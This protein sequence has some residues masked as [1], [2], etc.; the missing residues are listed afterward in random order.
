MIRVL[1]YET[2][3]FVFY[4]M[5]LSFFEWWFHKFMFHSPK[6]SKR[7][8]REHTLVHHQEFKHEP[9]SYEWHAPREKKNISMDWWSLPLFIVTLAP[10][11]VL[12]QFITHIPT[13][14]GG[15]A[16]VVVYY[17]IYE[18][19]HYLMHVPGRFWIEKTRFFQFVKEHHRI[20]H[21]YMLKNLNVFFPLA[22]V[23]MGTYR[24]ATSPS[25]V[26][27]LA[28]RK[29]ERAEAVLAVSAQAAIEPSPTPAD[30]KARSKQ[31]QG[32]KVS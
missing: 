8:F 13:F 28:L 15:I 32:A 9:E 6:L 22:D 14:W 26:D 25:R 31:A 5:C 11:F 21:K 27:R 1:L 29:R 19:L 2:L 20:H 23:V 12:M 4:F 24:T 10:A 17:A 16:A 7:T 18:G 3:A 30:V